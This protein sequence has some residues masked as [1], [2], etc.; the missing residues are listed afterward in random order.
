MRKYEMMHESRVVVLEK[1]RSCGRKLESFNAGVAGNVNISHRLSGALTLIYTVHWSPF[2][3]VVCI[4]LLS[5]AAT[6][7]LPPFQV[8]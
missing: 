3:P 8:K 5:L 7:Y 2:S 6:Q 1:R 4:S